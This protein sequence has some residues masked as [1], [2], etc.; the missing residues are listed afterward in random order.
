VLYNCSASR[1][2]IEGKTNEDSKEVQTE[3]LT[4]KATP[5]ANGMVKA[6]TGNTT[7]AT[8]YNDWYKAVYMPTA[9]AQ[10]AVQ[11]AA[12]SASTKSGS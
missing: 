7:D 2:G 3:T 4:I 10:A 11:S 6:K 1:P 5:L 9:E 12:K 8:V